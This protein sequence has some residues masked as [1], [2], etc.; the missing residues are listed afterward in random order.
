M[1][2]KRRQNGKLC[3]AMLWAMTGQGGVFP[4]VQTAESRGVVP[5]RSSAFA[6]RLA[7]VDKGTHRISP[8]LPILLLLLLPSLALIFQFLSRGSI[9]CCSLPLSLHLS[10]LH[11]RLL[12]GPRSQTP[13]DVSWPSLNTPGHAPAATCTG[14]AGGRAGGRAGVAPVMDTCS[15]S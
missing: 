4:Q 10:C 15:N 7:N 2:A 12:L 6:H 13:P 8:S 11:V 3:V 9:L 5:G 14:L 1:S